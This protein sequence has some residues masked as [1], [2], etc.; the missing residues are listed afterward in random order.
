MEIFHSFSLKNEDGE[1]E[2]GWGYKEIY[3][4]LNKYVLGKSK[5]QNNFQI[6]PV[7]FANN[8]KW[9]NNLPTGIEKIRDFDI[10]KLHRNEKPRTTQAKLY[11]TINL[12]KWLMYINSKCILLSLLILVF[13]IGLIVQQIERIQTINYSRKKIEYIKS[14]WKTQQRIQPRIIIPKSERTSIEDSIYIFF[15]RKDSLF[16]IMDELP[17][18]NME[19]EV[20]E[21]TRANLVKIGNTH[22]SYRKSIMLLDNLCSKIIES[23]QIK[24]WYNNGDSLK[25]KELL[26]NILYHYS[27]PKTSSIKQGTSITE[28]NKKIEITTKTNE[29]MKEYLQ[30]GKIKKAFELHKRQYDNNLNY[31]L[32]LNQ[33]R[34]LL[35]DEAELLNYYLLDYHGN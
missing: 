3:H 9:P 15:E 2:L 5:K 12:Q 29:K 7:T 24:N 33:N 25:I 21:F 19:V 8:F 22:I 27:P 30:H 16:D 26:C 28:L 23:P 17:T 1:E 10:C 35:E 11:T 18:F 32:L 34:E 31:W 6:L 13:G 14:S 4:A 20:D